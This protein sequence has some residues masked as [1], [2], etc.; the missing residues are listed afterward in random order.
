MFVFECRRKLARLPKAH[1]E[2]RFEFVPTGRVSKLKIPDTDR[3]ILWPLFQKYR[4]GFFSVKI[5]CIRAK[6]LKCLVE[7]SRS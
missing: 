6:K 5:D 1:R 3:R 7:E 4:G 2:G